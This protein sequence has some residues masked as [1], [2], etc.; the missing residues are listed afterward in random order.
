M[1]PISAG[2]CPAPVT[3]PSVSSAPAPADSGRCDAAIPF[4]SRWLFSLDDRRRGYERV[5]RQILDVGGCARP[6]RLRGTALTVALA[7]GLVLR[8]FSSDG[9]PFGAILVRCMNR[10]AAVCPSCSALYQ[11][12]AFQLARAGL[13]GGKGVPSWVRLNPALFVTLTSPSFGAVHR[14]V[15]PDDPRDRC[16]V[17]RGPVKCPHGRARKCTARHGPGDPDVGGPLCPDCYDYVGHVAF[18]V[19]CSALFGNLIDTVYHRLAAVGGVSR[20]AVRRLLRVEYLRI[21]EYQARGVIHFHVI[22]RLDGPQD[23]QA[24]AAWATAEVLADAVR[25][26]AATVSVAVP[27]SGALGERAVRFGEQI[28]VQFLTLGGT[29]EQLHEHKVSGYVA[30]YLTKGVESARGVNRPIRHAW[31]IDVLVK[32]P[33]IRA[34]MH[35][36]WRLG[37]LRELKALRLR[38]WCHT[39]G[40]RGHAVTKSR[41]F[42]TTFTRL[43]AD[44]VAYH[45]RNDE[46]V[47]GGVASVSEFVFV[48]QGYPSASLAAF[49]AQEYRGMVESRELAR[50]ALALER[51]AGQSGPAPDLRGPGWAGGAA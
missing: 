28:D 41:R 22:F 49:A 7:S 13:V 24:S 15:N 29:D 31:Q 11:G 36:C 38:A 25:S 51:A 33:H 44:R 5:R 8:E 16:H 48:D 30:K 20:A 35:A 39:L 4:A 42:S 19:L 40:F 32:S 3:Q 12:D 45:H 50:D 27:V 1:S 9:T 34:L 18:N 14:A 26:A 43:R 10:R 46:P 21:A 17:R 23:R 47:P 2:A 6:I 37:G